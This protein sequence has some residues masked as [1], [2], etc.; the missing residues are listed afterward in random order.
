M[1]KKQRHAFVLLHIDDSFKTTNNISSAVE[2]LHERLKDIE[3][4]RKGVD[5]TCVKN[6][7]L[8][9]YDANLRVSL[10]GEFKSVREDFID[11]RSQ[12]QVLYN[13]PDSIERLLNFKQE[14]LQVREAVDVDSAVVEKEKPKSLSRGLLVK[15]QNFSK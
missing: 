13:K 9:T 6:E 8:E 3:E 4:L 10:D 5:E 11:V 15:T 1:W 12:I 14:P 7:N 2:S